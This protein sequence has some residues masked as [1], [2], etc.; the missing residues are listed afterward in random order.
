M[1]AMSDAIL[2]MGIQVLRGDGA[3]I[4]VFTPIDGVT[5][6]T[7]VGIGLETFDVTAHALSG[8]TRLSAGLK[9]L[10]PMSV[11]LLWDP[12][13]ET[14]GYTITGILDAIDRR[15]AQ[16]YRV[17]FPDAAS[18]AWTFEAMI[19]A[20]IIDAPTADGLVA[21]VT[22]TPTGYRI[23]IPAGAT[24][25]EEEEEEDMGIMLQQVKTTYSEVLSTTSVIPL[26]DS[27]PQVG[28]GVEWMSQA[29]VP[30]LA[31]S[32]LRVEVVASIGASSGGASDGILALFRDGAA[33]AINAVWVSAT[34]SVAHFVTYV[35]AGSVAATTFTVRLGTSSGATTMRVNARP[36]GGRLFGA[37]PKSVITITEVAG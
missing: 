7:G 29:I 15:L 11:G 33:D 3:A 25:P 1:R 30:T 6:V 13:D 37:T 12:T 5:H 31:T 2:G 10:K 16:M 32:I 4:E 18:T 34:G 14:H 28:E 27:V 24:A 26:D 19:T 9:T 20:V 36:G 23:D 8:W 21:E 35:A 22:I 17:V